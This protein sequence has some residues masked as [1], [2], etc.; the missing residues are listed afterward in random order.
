MEQAGE[1]DERSKEGNEGGGWQTRT[2]GLL[3]NSS[4]TPPNIRGRQ[5]EAHDGLATRKGGR[6]PPPL[7][8]SETDATT[9]GTDG[10][11]LPSGTRVHPIMPTAIKGSVK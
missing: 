5:K 6:K 4:H 1:K 11:G 10:A 8:R 2:S 9:K 3:R 7:L